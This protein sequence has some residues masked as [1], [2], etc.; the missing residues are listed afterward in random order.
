MGWPGWRVECRRD[1]FWLL[2]AA[3]VGPGGIFRGVWIELL[4]LC[5]LAF[6]AEALCFRF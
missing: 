6:G 4:E 3:R 5:S 2:S 1:S